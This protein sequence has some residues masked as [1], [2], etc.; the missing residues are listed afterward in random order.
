MKRILVINEA[1]GFPGCLG[2][3][4]CQHWPWK[5]CPVAWAGQFKGKERK[6]TV[7][8]EAIADGEGWIWPIFVG[9]AGSI[10]VIVLGNA[11]HSFRRV[12][13]SHCVYYKLKDA[14]S[15]LLAWRRDISGLCD[16]REDY[17]GRG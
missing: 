3:I 9:H 16:I 7:A 10:N 12:S 4:D 2:S 14:I 5:N 15:S 17:Q 13:S 8:I 1:R 6:P 11:A